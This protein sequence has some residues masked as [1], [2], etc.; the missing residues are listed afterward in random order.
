MKDTMKY[1]Y[2]YRLSW[3][4]LP[5][6]LVLLSWIPIIKRINLLKVSSTQ[7]INTK[8]I[9]NVQEYF[10][11][12]DS[13]AGSEKDLTTIMSGRGFTY[14]KHGLLSANLIVKEE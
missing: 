2:S 9:L 12:N 8:I 14:S 3:A 10:K 6:S 13:I 4:V 7:C 1:F 5:W 11:S